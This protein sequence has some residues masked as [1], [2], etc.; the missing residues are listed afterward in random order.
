MSV[1]TVRV[2]TE[3]SQRA[4]QQQLAELASC[5]KKAKLQEL[6][7]R[8]DELRPFTSNPPKGGNLSPRDQSD[9][10]IEAMKSQFNDLHRKQLDK[11]IKR[12]FLLRLTSGEDVCDGDDTA[13]YD[14]GSD[15]SGDIKV[16]EKDV[17]AMKED[18]NTQQ[19][20]LLK[21]QI[22]RSFNLRTPREDDDVDFIDIETEQ[23]LIADSGE[24]ESKYKELNKVMVRLRSMKT[25]EM[26]L[27]PQIKPQHKE[28][29]TL[30]L[31]DIGIVNE[32]IIEQLWMN[33][34]NT[35]SYEVPVEEQEIEEEEGE[36]EMGEE[37]R[38]DQMIAR[39]QKEN[40]L[41]HQQIQTMQE[42]QIYVD[43]DDDEMLIL[44]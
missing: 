23:K 44:N 43:S 2:L 16:D 29:F 34:Q 17:A 11:Q 5:H 10:E 24:M 39:L 41:L 7:E 19:K 37:E 28:Q 40:E 15:G 13:G 27:M 42:Q 4:M 25:L 18:F 22:E 26:G 12:Q 32:C 20:S 21:K 38:K 8:Q 35:V 33:I 30:L 9:E 14:G 6:F 3:A 1:P 31:Q 36:E